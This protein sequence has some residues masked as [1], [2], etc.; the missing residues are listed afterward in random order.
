[1]DNKTRLMLAFVAAISSMASS[2]AWAFYC[3]TNGTRQ[4]SGFT[5]SVPVN[6]V[7]LRKDTN[8][9]IAITDMSTY[10]TCYAEPSDNLRVSTAS[11]NPELEARGFIGVLNIGG[12][13]FDMPATGQYIFPYPLSSETVSHQILPLRVGIELR[14]GE[15]GA[16]AAGVTLPAGTILATLVAEQRSFAVWGWPDTWNFV[17]N[18]PLVIPAYTCNVTNTESQRVILPDVD[19]SELRG[20]GKGI[21]TNSRTRFSINL[22]CD[23]MA[24]VDMSID[25][26]KMT[27][28]DDVLANLE[29]GNDNIGIRVFPAGNTTTPIVF[30]GSTNRVFES[31]RANESFEYDAY[32][33]YNGGRFFPGTVRANMTYT[34]S[35][36]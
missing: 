31:A 22:A 29:S 23:E 24:T 25:G 11:I 30:D 21:F 5:V 35:Y 13:R 34:F 2:G 27:G 36:R 19:R 16:W 10:T 20:I 28:K 14:R 17:L 32:Y 6:S 15:R 18:S 26:T 9:I 1:M 33:Y 8:S 3:T 7:V 12:T 4:M